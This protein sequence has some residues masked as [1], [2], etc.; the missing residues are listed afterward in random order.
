MQTYNFDDDDKLDRKDLAVQL[1]KL[2]QNSEQYF[3]EKKSLVIALDSPWGTGKSMFL[4]MW[5]NYINANE[6][7]DWKVLN[8]NAWYDDDFDYP[9][10]PIIS[11]LKDL[12][13]DKEL[14]KELSQKALHLIKFAVTQTFPLGLKLF[15]GIDTKDVI[16]GLKEIAAGSEENDY[17]DK[18]K[19][20]KEV[21]RNFSD[22]IKKM[23]A[24]DKVIFLIDELD[25]CRPT[26]AIETLETIKHLFD[27]KNLVFIIALDMEQLK[28]SISTIYGANMDSHGYLRRFFDFNIRIPSPSIINY[29]AHLDRSHLLESDEIK[30]E[31]A[32]MFKGLN[33]TLRDINVIFTNFKIM[34]ATKLSEISEHRN[35]KMILFMYLIAMKHKNPDIYKKMLFEKLSI[36]D[37]KI[38]FI[39]NDII[40]EFL[41][42]LENGLSRTISSLNSSGTNEYIYLKECL[43]IA[44]ITDE[45]IPISMYIENNMEIFSD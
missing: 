30:K 22:V 44:N 34:L 28:H 11:E 41:K 9:L 24:N 39:N 4:E 5:K 17:I 27:I 13:E 7:I 26:Y 1:N 20:F 45:N 18:Y 23:A 19:Q 38:L 3:G 31:I 43:F 35:K 12:C 25:R 40:Q 32:D 16:D 21:K 6:E 15:T 42:I 29:I 36:E 2:I 37:I 10:I 8:Y 14:K 33:L